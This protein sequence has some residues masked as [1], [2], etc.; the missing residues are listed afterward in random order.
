MTGLAPVKKTGNW[1][2]RLLSSACG[3]RVAPASCR[4][5]P[6]VRARRRLVQ[7]RRDGIL[8]P[9]KLARHE[10]ETGD[11]RIR[12][13]SM[14]DHLPPAVLVRPVRTCAPGRALTFNANEDGATKEERQPP[15]KRP[16]IISAQ[17]IER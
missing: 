2:D 11:L 15:I 5:Q 4:P 6:D 1:Q 13:Q 9:A 12:R 8:R 10:L 16:R 3:S 17:I 14:I 7:G